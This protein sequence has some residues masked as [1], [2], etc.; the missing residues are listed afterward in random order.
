MTKHT[1]EFDERL[2][3]LRNPKSKNKIGYRKRKQEEREADEQLKE[4]KKHES[5]EDNW[6]S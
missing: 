4:Y 6:L 3:E 5:S 1:K 2:Q